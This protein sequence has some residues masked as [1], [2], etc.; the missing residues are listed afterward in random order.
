[1]SEEITSKA[2]V[3]VD[4]L[5]N[6]DLEQMP[7]VRENMATG[8]MNAGD[9]YVTPVVLGSIYTGASPSTNGLPS[10]SRYEQPS[11]LRPNGPTIPEMAAATTDYENVLQLG[12]PFIVPPQV[13]IEGNYWHVS[14]AMGQ[15][16][17]NPGEA[18]PTLTIPAPAGQLDSPEENL[19][20]AF[21]LRVDHCMT[22]FGTARN[23]LAMWDV[24]L[25]FISYRVPDSYCHYHY[26]EGGD[27]GNTYREDLLQQV[28]REISYLANQAEVFVF[29]DHG[30]RELSTLVRVNRWLIEHGYLEVEV[31]HEWRKRAR[32]YGVLDDLDD[33]PGD[34]VQ[35]GEP[36]VTIDEEASVAVGADP[37]SGGI[38]LLEGATGQAVDELVDE[39]SAVD[40]IAGVKTRRELFGHGPLLE[41]CPDLYAIREPGTFVSG[42]LAEEVG[43][44]EVTRSGVHH[45][46]G[47]YGATSGLT[48]PDGRVSPR[49]LFS[50]IAEDFLGL[51]V[52][53]V[54]QAGEAAPAVADDEDAVRENLRDLGYL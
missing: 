26:A 36:G 33:V 38:T 8:E 43:G 24:D 12:L 48:P 9:V 21:N 35:V 5:G 31:D 13:D 25:A 49:R 54:D 16:A 27:S 3:F 23:L 37:F 4:S 51:D 14:E 52:D 32:E 40:G 45:P 10:V 47:A 42:N 34:V 6:D 44:P 17:F 20:L 18:Q 29:G 39:L 15:Q 22:T 53:A 50:L 2:V 1:M 46:I 30:A 28:D 11:R 7:F 19:D 41:E